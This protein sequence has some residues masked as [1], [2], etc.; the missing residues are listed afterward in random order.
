[1]QVIN[2]IYKWDA[3]P[4]CI[5]NTYKVKDRFSAFSKVRMRVFSFQKSLITYFLLSRS[6]TYKR[7]GGTE[8]LK[9]ILLSL[10]KRKKKYYI[11]I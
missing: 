11:F 6:R 5:I 1:M 7:K 2:E 8:K 9:L 3:I 4:L 10:G